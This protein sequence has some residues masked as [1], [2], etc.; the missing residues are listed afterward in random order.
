MFVL[1][2][3]LAWLRCVALDALRIRTAWEDSGS[4]K[5]QFWVKGLNASVGGRKG[6]RRQNQENRAKVA[7]CLGAKKALALVH[8]AD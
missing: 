3:D 8:A 4:S 7:L 1:E 6:H 5:G 2:I